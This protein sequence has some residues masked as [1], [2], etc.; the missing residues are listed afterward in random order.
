MPLS[1]S[2]MRSFCLLILM[3]ISGAPRTSAISAV[4]DEI[5]NDFRPIAGVVVMAS[6]GEYIIDV[7]ESKGVIIGDLFSVLTAGKKIIHP[8]SGK[9]LGT[10][11]EVKAIL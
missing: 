8:K 5:S 1:T 4:I 7:D 6:D 11:E 9:V 2:F 10:L 3:I